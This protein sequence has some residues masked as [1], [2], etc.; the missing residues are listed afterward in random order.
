MKTHLMTIERDIES[1]RISN[2]IEHARLA[3]MIRSVEI[4]KRKR[5]REREKKA[6][7]E[8]T[9]FALFTNIKATFFDLKKKFDKGR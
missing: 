8:I 3:P 2:R 1:R 7:Q 5:E 6:S 4:R 9:K